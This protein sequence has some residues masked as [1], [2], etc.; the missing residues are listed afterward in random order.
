MKIL[1]LKDVLETTGL[2]KTSIYEFISQGRFPKSIPLGGRSVGWVD[3]E[4]ENWIKSRIELRDNG[5]DLL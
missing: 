4:V 5:G 1:R 3:T 2:S